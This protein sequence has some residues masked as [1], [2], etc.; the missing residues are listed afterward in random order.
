MMMLL[1]SFSFSSHAQTQSGFEV[2]GT[3][4]DADNVPIPYANI[5]EKGTTNGVVS[6]FDGN[7]I[8]EVKDG[9]TSELVFSLIG[10]MLIR[11]DT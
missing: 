6:D 4:A 11:K 3:I 10:F 8:I 7:Y 2:S 1:L 5:I 9:E